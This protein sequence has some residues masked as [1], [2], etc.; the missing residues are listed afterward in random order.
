MLGKS[1]AMQLQ[2]DG[3]QVRVFARD[4]NKAQVLFDDSFEFVQGDVLRPETISEALENC[5]GVHIS[6]KGGPTPESYDHI[7]HKGTAAVAN[8]A[9]KAGIDQLTFLSGASTSKVNSWFYV[10][11]AKYDAENA[12]KESGVDFTIFRA[13]WFMESIPLFIKGN[14]IIKLGKQLSPVHWIAAKEYAGIVSKSFSKSEAKNK[15]LYIY[16]SESIPL[17]A[18]FQTY[19]TIVRPDLHISTMPIWLMKIIATLSQNAELKDA[20]NLMDYYEKITEDADPSET[21]ELFGKPQITLN[22]WCKSQKEV[23]MGKVT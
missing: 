16:G 20:A 19:C 22:K 4:I 2:K 10:P 15:I 23:S 13:S 14:K 12:I 11:K 1:V 17:S 6:L 3:Y 8:L 9:Q 18:A 7:E 5:D 21:F